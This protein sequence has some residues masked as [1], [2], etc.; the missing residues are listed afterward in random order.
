M[1]IFDLF[2]LIPLSD[3]S[4]L[5]YSLLA[6]PSSRLASH[7]G[8]TSGRVMDTADSRQSRR[9]KLIGKQGAIAIP[10]WV[11]RSADASVMVSGTLSRALLSH[12]I[13]GS[14][15]ETWRRGHLLER[16]VVVGGCTT[17]QGVQ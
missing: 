11:A 4:S 14:G 8:V 1:S 7:V 12:N 17:Y 9:L 6:S 15:T 3:L 13:L 5:I 16:C 2:S 10:F